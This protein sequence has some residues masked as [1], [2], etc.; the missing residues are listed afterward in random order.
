MLYFHGDVE[1]CHKV[2]ARTRTNGCNRKLDS[3]T[4][5]YCKIAVSESNRRSKAQVPNAMQAFRLRLSKLTTKLREERAPAAHAIAHSPSATGAAPW[6]A[7]Y[8]PAAR[9]TAPAGAIFGIKL[10]PRASLTQP[11]IAPP[12]SPAR[13]PHSAQTTR[14]RSPCL[15]YQQQRPARA[16]ILFSESKILTSLRLYIFYIFCLHVLPPSLRR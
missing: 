12:T 2:T 16:Q 15:F 13:L 7:P 3:T 5:A 6:H 10:S 11:R 9:P 8:L 4:E 1:R 14:P